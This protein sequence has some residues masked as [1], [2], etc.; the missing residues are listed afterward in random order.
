MCEESRIVIKM[1]LRLASALKCCGLVTMLIN[2]GKGPFLFTK[3]TIVLEQTE[4]TQE[5]EV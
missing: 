1:A 5:S 4:A 2:Q 3:L